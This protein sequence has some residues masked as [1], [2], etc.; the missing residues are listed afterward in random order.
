MKQTFK[1]ITVFLTIITFATVAIPSATVVYAVESTSITKNKE[2]LTP[3]T[4]MTDEQ[5]ESL[6]IKIQTLHPDVSLE[7]IKEVIHRQLRGDYSMPSTD[8]TLFRAGWQGI[9]VNQMGAAIDTTISL[10]LGGSTAGL[11]ALIR[12]KGKHAVRSA[13]RS[14]IAKHLRGW[15]VN[16]VAIDF[17]MNLLSPG[18]YIAQQWDARDAVPNNGRINF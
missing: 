12:V 9:T 18:T 11:A 7:W 16:S 15:F 10:L 14:A 13:I 4:A 17:A 1:F 8:I 2:N 6:A 5:I 3:V